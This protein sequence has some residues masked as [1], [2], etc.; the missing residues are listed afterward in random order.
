MSDTLL[1]IETATQMCSAALV[2]AGRVYSRSEQGNNIHSQRLLPMVDTLLTEADVTANDLDAVAVGQ[3]PGSFTGLRIGVGV[4]QGLAYA[5]GC[6]MIGIASLSALAM[7]VKQSQ[8]NADVAI[9]GV[10]ARMGEVYYARYDLTS[11]L[12][13]VI[14]EVQVLA[15]EQIIP[16]VGGGVL[17]GNAWA[18]YQE[19]LPKEL[20]ELALPH[21]ECVLP[22]A[23][24]MLPM[25]LDALE[26]GNTVDPSRFEPDYVRNNVAN[27]KGGN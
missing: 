25:A 21:Q 9:V 15:P 5:A 1:V 17:A 7:Q 2:A 13:S 8:L 27:V 4:G 16:L 23:E 18:E 10:D 12:P 19:Q 14:D 26:Q 6:P 3:G 24:A 20:A 11:A 22:R